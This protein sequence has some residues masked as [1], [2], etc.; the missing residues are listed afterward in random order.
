MVSIS[1]RSNDERLKRVKE[2]TV[3]MKCD[4]LIVRASTAVI[5]FNKVSSERRYFSSENFIIHYKTRSWRLFSSMFIVINQTPKSS[6]KVAFC[7][8]CSISLF[9]SSHRFSPISIASHIVISNSIVKTR[10]KSA[11]THSIRLPLLRFILSRNGFSCCFSRI[12]VMIRLISI[13]W[14][15]RAPRFWVADERC[16]SIQYVFFFLFFS[17][18]LL[19]LI[20]TQPFNLLTEYNPISLGKTM[21]KWFRRSETLSR[22]QYV[23][24]DMRTRSCCSSRMPRQ[25]GNFI[26]NHFICI[27]SSFSEIVFIFLTPPFCLC[28]SS[29]LLL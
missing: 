29:K 28:H 7:R 14:P 24:H 11:S 2:N 13:H 15:R 3:C 4:W 26:N 9:L 10:D 25:F 22:H 18:L 5:Q 27:F 8:Q 12:D 20:V 19:L 23:I 1:K 6:D 21:S 16:L 17:F